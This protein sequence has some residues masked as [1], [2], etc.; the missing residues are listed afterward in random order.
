MKVESTLDFSTDGESALKFERFYSSNQA[1][2]LGRIMPSRLGKGWRSNFDS[3]L[4]TPGANSWISVVLPTGEVFYFSYTGSGYAQSYFDWDIYGWLQPGSKGRVATL[5]QDTVAQTYSVTTD[6]GTVWDYG[7]DGK[8]R[9]I[10]L[11]NGYSQSLTYDSSGNN[12]LVTDSFGRTL[13]FSYS[14]QGLLTSVTVPGGQVYQYSYLALYNPSAFPGLSS[15][16][17]ASDLWA[18]EYVIQPDST[19]SGSDNPRIR[20]HY[21]TPRSPLR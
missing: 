5:V 19:P 4:Y 1:A 21:E 12:S 6:D 10:A 8:L 2:I 13:T 16:V 20:Y 3:N 7:Y 18:L 11:R 9:T 17:F 15:D 14:P